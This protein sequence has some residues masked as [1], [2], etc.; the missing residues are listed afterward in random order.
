MQSMQPRSRATPDDVRHAY[1]LLLGREPDPEGFAL[2]SRMIH[3][4][5]LSI[6][7]LASIFI[8]SQEFAARHQR[9]D[10]P[11]EVQ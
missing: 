6:A 8:G 11:T 4:G 1:E 5:N 9:S 10:T 7:D 2:Y 3:S